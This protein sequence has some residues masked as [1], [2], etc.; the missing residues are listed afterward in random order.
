LIAASPLTKNRASKRD[1]DMSQTMK[2]NPWYFGMMAHIGV[3]AQS[4]RV[5]PVKTT[6]G[7]VHMQKSPTI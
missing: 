3:D 6:T 1:P 5:H 7:K 2:G 4:G